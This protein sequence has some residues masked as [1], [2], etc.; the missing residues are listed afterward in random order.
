MRAAERREFRGAYAT[1][2]KDNEM[3]RGTTPFEVTRLFIY[4]FDQL[5]LHYC[6][7][8][9]CC[10]CLV[11]VVKISFYWEYPNLFCCCLCWYPELLLVVVVDDVLYIL[12]VANL[13]NCCDLLSL[14][15]I[16]YY[17]CIY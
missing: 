9:N 10:S 7:S 17:C 6:Y 13:I 8:C 12:H 2:G 5:Y 16:L 1:C 14:D 11:V 3:R 4:L 15:L